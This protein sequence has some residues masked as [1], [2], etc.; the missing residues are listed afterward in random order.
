MYLGNQRKAPKW[1]LVG[2]ISTT[3]TQYLIIYFKVLK[4]LTLIFIL[5]YL[6]LNRNL[7]D[8]DYL[9]LAKYLLLAY[10]MINKPP[11]KDTHRIT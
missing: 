3:S 10:F 11:K 2:F 1:A 9:A 6:Y 4:C 5:R 7:A 8:L